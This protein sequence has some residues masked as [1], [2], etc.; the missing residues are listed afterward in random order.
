MSELQHSKIGSEER[1]THT[2]LP[3][4]T[5]RFADRRFSPAPGGGRSGRRGSDSNIM[6][7]LSP[8]QLHSLLGGGHNNGQSAPLGLG[9]SAG[10]MSSV[11]VSSATAQSF[12][13][14]S[15]R[16]AL[17]LSIPSSPHAGSFTQ[18]ALPLLP[19]SASPFQG[20]AA[21]STSP[22]FSPVSSSTLTPSSQPPAVPGLPPAPAPGPASTF[23]A[24]RL[25]ARRVS[26]PYAHASLSDEQ[27]SQLMGFG[28]GG[29]GGGGGA[30]GAPSPPSALALMANRSLS[31]G[32]LVPQKSPRQGTSVSMIPECVFACRVALNLPCTHTLFISRRCRPSPI[33]LLHFL[34]RPSIYVASSLCVVF[35]RLFFHTFPPQAHIAP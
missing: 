23:I 25:G 21:H 19:A 13:A 2:A 17:S 9:V 24:R 32:R 29:G 15:P 35:P 20:R 30:A 28:G 33:R 27:R 22:V 5:V 31:S 4:S 26:E 1:D 3:V 18:A 14:P 11:D 6:Q 8:T 16:N 7:Q 34:G 12:Q 10:G